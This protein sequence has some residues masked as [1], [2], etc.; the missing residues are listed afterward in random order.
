MIMLNPL[1]FVN[2]L[3]SVSVM[4]TTSGRKYI[5]SMGL[6]EETD[7]LFLQL[8]KLGMFVPVEGV[9][10]DGTE[11][12]G[13]EGLWH[14]WERKTTVPNILQW[15]LQ[16]FNEVLRQAWVPIVYT[17]LGLQLSPDPRLAPW[18]DRM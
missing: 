4:L 1:L 3:E 12:D 17:V 16:Q 8:I 13:P 5:N 9:P 15:L 6:W 11:R 10:S 7:Q 14:W 18:T 2:S